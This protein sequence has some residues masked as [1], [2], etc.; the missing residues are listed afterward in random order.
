MFFDSS[1]CL[2]PNETKFYLNKEDFDYLIEDNVCDLQDELDNREMRIEL[3]MV[4][5]GSRPYQ[6]AVRNSE[7]KKELLERRTEIEKYWG[8]EKIRLFRLPNKKY[9][10]DNDPEN[11][12]NE[13]EWRKEL[14][15]KLKLK[16]VIK[17][18]TLTEEESNKWE[19]FLKKIEEESNKWEEQK[20]EEYQTY[21]EGNEEEEYQKLE[22]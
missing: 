21:L 17:K 9:E 7:L 16:K 10:M 13:P 1:R 19:E 15:L 2:K 6:M 18:R 20:D 8:G 14:K 22:K 5:D 11:P 3:V 12:I 4:D